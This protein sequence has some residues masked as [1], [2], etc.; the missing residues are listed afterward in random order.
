MRSLQLRSA[1]WTG[2]AAGRMESGF[3]G[4]LQSLTLPCFTGVL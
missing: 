1:R 4:V 3:T 2:T